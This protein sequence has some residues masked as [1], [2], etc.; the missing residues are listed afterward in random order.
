[1]V[2]LFLSGCRDKNHRA[3][4]KNKDQQPAL[5]LQNDYVTKNF[6]AI[7]DGVECAA[8]AQ[9][10]VSIA[11][12]LDGVVLADYHATDTSY[13]HGTLR[14]SYACDQQEIAYDQLDTLLK[15]E[16]FT[17]SQL[18]GRFLVK[19]QI[20]QAKPHVLFNGT[21]IPV[22]LSCQAA[23]KLFYRNVNV[24]TAIMGS[25]CPASNN[26]WVLHVGA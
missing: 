6:C 14:F 1:M 13:E 7:I 4:R 9:D 11:K 8:C 24:D 21:L 20:A 3:Q 23:T 12:Q 18:T 10:V 15:Q 2:L 22:K 17:L 16:G 5:S 25:L 26:Q 19:P